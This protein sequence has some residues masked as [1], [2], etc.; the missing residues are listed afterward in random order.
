VVIAF[1]EQNIFKGKKGKIM[2]EILTKEDKSKITKALAAIADVK[3]EIGKAKLA[4]IDVEAQT[5][6][7]LETELKLLSIKRVYF[8]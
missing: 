2:V 7:L 1:G 4:G 6:T 8:P 3:K 5:K